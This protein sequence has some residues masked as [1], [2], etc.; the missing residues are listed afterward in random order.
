[1]GRY[2][3]NCSQVC[4]TGTYGLNC[5]HQC[6]CTG[7]EV[8]DPA[9]GCTNVTTTLSPTTLSQSTARIYNS[10]SMNSGN[11]YSYIMA[12]DSSSIVYPMFTKEEIDKNL[13]NP[14]K[15]IWQ[16]GYNLRESNLKYW[17]MFLGFFFNLSN[18]GGWMMNNEIQVLW[19]KMWILSLK[20]NI[21]YCFSHVITFVYFV[22][23]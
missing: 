8:C 6:Y 18:H 7:D 12:C 15:S 13:E 9:V 23:R 11:I 5:Y 16:K 21:S 17:F 3:C 1:M 4:S 22:C 10:T 20:L 2:G 14:L 19:S